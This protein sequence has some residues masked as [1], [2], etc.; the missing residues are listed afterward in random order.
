MPEDYYSMPDSESESEQTDK[1]EKAETET[2]LTAKSVLG[3]KEA[4]PG[5]EWIFRIVRMYDDEIEWEY[6]TDDKKEKKDD[7]P[8]PKSAM[9]ESMDD[10]GKMA[11]GY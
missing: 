10:M 3:G 9:D 8:E 11:G 6:A 5:S 4:E 7:K 2:F 1:Q